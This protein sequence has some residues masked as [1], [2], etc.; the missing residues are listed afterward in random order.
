MCIKHKNIYKET[1]R[2]ELKTSG[3]LSLKQLILKS[4]LIKREGIRCGF[5]VVHKGLPHFF[6]QKFELHKFQTCVMCFY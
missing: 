1:V 3:P 2:G 6:A 5:A 4:K